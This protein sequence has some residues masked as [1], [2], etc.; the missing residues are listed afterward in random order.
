MA[1]RRTGSARSKN[2]GND[3]SSPLAASIRK[4]EADR[5]NIIGESSVPLVE[6][7]LNRDVVSVL[8]EIALPI[9]DVGII[10]F[11]RRSKKVMLECRRV[12]VNIQRET[13]IGTGNYVAN[14][15]VSSFIDAH[16]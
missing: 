15:A 9:T 1:I 8:F 13:R 12:L 4:V 6:K 16:C 10:V 7:A 5:I 14:E 11:D 3:P 2:V